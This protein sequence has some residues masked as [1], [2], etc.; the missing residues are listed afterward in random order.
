MVFSNWRPSQK[1]LGST[2]NW[3]TINGSSLV[4]QLSNTAAVLLQSKMNFTVR[5]PVFSAFA[6]L[7][8]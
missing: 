8:K 4:G 5:G 7:A 3:P 2:G 1:C 6:T